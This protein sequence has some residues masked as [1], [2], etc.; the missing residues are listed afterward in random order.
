VRQRSADSPPQWPAGSGASSVGTCMSY[1]LVQL[2]R[3]QMV[4]L[5][6]SQMPAGA[7]PGLDEDALPPSFVA[8]RSLAQMAEGKSEH[9]CGTFLIVRSV[10]QRVV[11]ACGFKDEPRA[12]RVD[13]QSETV[14]LWLAPHDD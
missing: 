2:S 11:G 9:W 1:T 10:D 7:A 12:G 5:A 14:V 13:E 3:E 8:R 4:D 6:E